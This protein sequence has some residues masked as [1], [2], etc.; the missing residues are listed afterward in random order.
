MPYE[1]FM[2]HHSAC[3]SIYKKEYDF[4]ISSDSS[5]IVA[6]VLSDHEYIHI[7]LEGH[8]NQQYELMSARAK[9]QLFTASKLI[10]ELSK[11]YEISPLYLHPHSQ[12]CPGSH[13]PWNELVIYPADGY[14]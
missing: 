13:F 4:W 1:G 2:I 3:S 10:M 12:V 6:P 7:C 5:I 9:Q 8:F 11:L 14:H